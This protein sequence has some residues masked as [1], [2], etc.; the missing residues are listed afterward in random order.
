[1][2]EASLTFTE[3]W[4]PV[5]TDFGLIEAPVE[6]SCSEF[7][8]WQKSLCTKPT[9]AQ[10]FPV[11]AGLL[12]LAPLSVELRRSLFVPTRSR[13]TAFFQSGIL[14][15]D[16]SPPMGVLA[17]RLKVHTMRV[18]STEPGAMWP[19]TIWE[20]FAPP[21]LGGKGPL[22]C[23]RMIAAANDGGSWTF[24][25]S[26]EPFGFENP[27]AYQARRKRERFTR[28]IM[29]RYLR[30]FDARV[31]DEAFYVGTQSQPTILV[32]KERRW[33]SPPMEYSY[34]DVRAG[35]P[36]RRQQAVTE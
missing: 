6:V 11:S 34:E 17:E 20:V 36:W 13:W 15:S 7:V 18:C 22:L 19:A 30:E 31:F 23:R 33:S 32:Q 10:I 9:S 12:A 21:E 14:G 28:E 2:E 25:Q 29:A 16:P 8:R 24:A 26:G 3:Q 5:T 35:K 4:N 1:L 27:F